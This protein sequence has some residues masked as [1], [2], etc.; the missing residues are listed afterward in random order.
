METLRALT[1]RYRR[2]RASRALG[3]AVEAPFA[4]VVGQAVAVCVSGMVKKNRIMFVI[5]QR[6]AILL[7]LPR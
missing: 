2:F 7:T 4:V 5:P 6:A 1:H 3:L